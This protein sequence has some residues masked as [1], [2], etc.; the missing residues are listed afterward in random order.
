MMTYLSVLL[1]WLVTS[2][3]AF[4]P[5]TEPQRHWSSPLRGVIQSERVDEPVNI[6]GETA[7]GKIRTLVQAR[8]KERLEGNYE[9]ADRIRRDILE[10]PI[11]QGYE[12]WI[13]D[14]PRKLGGGSNW[15]LLW[16]PKELEDGLPG[17]KV[18]QLAHVAL[19]LAVESSK[20]AHLVRSREASLE[21]ADQLYFSAEDEKRKQLDEIVKQVMERLNQPAV[22]Y[23]LGG[24][25]AADSAF[26]FALAGVKD[27]ALFDSL[28]RLSTLEL[29]RFGDRASCRPKDVYQILERFAAAGVECGV[30]LR[31]AA[32]HSLESKGVEE[33]SQKTFLELHADRPL[34]LIWKFSTK[35]KK[36]R[37]FLQSALRHWERQKGDQSMP[38]E[39]AESYGLGSKL[40]SDAFDDATRPLVVDIGCGMGVSVLG[41]STCTDGSSSRNLIGKMNED[42][43]FEWKDCNYVGVDLGGLGIDYAKG[44]ASRWEIQGRTHF[45]I[46]AAEDFVERIRNE[47]PGPVQLCLIQFP[48]P[49]K[50]QKEEGSGNSQLPTSPQDGFMVTPRLLKLV[51]SMLTAK[52]KLLIQS[53]CEDVAVWMRSAACA[54]GNF[55]IVDSPG[56]E[57]DYEMSTSSP[58]IPQRTLDWIAMDGARADGPGWYTKPLLPRK[59]AT[60]TEVA[61]M[62][63]GTPVHRCLLSNRIK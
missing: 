56:M 10:I 62:L 3:S 45:V 20:Q 28:V 1:L 41:L 4:V 36:Q 37:V 40:W 19:G 53:N 15:A 35:Q 61:C 27:R 25:K 50:L 63:N 44:V 57:Q 21:G 42:E 8:S 26:W 49:Y 14:I 43:P 33:E 9:N 51:S 22:Q 32:M 7:V 60:E 46:G 12:I 5:T 16:K 29:E 58:R 18:L 55:A 48:T 47:Y 30:E 24:R 38:D 6:L 59:G 11:P 39:N 54:T 2:T 52:G 17:P 31:K 34:L 23:E 13:E